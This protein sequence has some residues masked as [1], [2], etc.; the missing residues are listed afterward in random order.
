MGLA[1]ALELNRH[2]GPAHVLELKDKLAMTPDQ[3]AATL[4]SF[5]RM[6]AAAKLLGDTHRSRE[7]QAAGVKSL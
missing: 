4:G 2:P 6:A 5:V 1:R 3:L 7:R